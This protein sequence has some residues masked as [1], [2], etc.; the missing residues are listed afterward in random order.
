MHL[1]LHEPLLDDS[2]SDLKLNMELTLTLMLLP[3]LCRTLTRC[4]APSS[5]CWA[6]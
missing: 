3:T 6:D 1:M 2:A 4:Y 5:C